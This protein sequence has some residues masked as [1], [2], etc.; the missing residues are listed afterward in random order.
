MELRLPEIPETVSYG[1]KAGST[2]T[3]SAFTRPGA[4]IA[5]RQ[6]IRMDRFMV[7]VCWF[8]ENRPTQR[9][10]LATYR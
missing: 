8:A 9:P 5:E 1:F 6:K 3:L 4:I 7:G 10:G 2:S